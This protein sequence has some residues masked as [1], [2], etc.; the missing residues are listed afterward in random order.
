MLLR[1]GFYEDA[2]MGYQ[3]LLGWMT[4]SRASDH[5]NIAC[6]YALWSLEPGDKEPAVLRGA[7][8]RNLDLAVREQW[9]DVGWMEEDRDL[10]PIRD[11]DE[12]RALVVRVR[13]TIAGDE[14]V[15]KPSPP[16]RR[17]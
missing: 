13:K 12:Y 17:R 10:D 11:T 3:E 8:L 5:Y 15:P 16:R 14:P 9:T 2:I 4:S 6:A 7:A 1:A